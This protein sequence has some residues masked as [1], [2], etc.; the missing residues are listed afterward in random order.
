MK[1]MGLNEVREKFLSFFESK[2][3]LRLHSFPLVPK[4]DKSLLLINS[5]MAP[6]KPYFTGQEAPP[7]K[8]V[9]TCQKCIR[10]PDIDNAGKTARHGTFFEMLGNF[11]FGDYFKKEA[12]SWGWE[13]MTKMM[14]IPYE[15]LYVSIYE[16]DDEA[17][18]IWK[19]IIGLPDE[20]IVRLGKDDNF[21]EIGTG[22]CGPCSEI[23][24]DR[25]ERFGCGKSTCK[26]GC[27]CDRYMEVWNLVF[28]QFNR[29]DEGNYTPLDFPNIDT[30]MGLE[31]MAAVMQEAD[32]IFE[33]D[34][35]KSILDYVCAMSNK[36][37]GKDEK[38][39]ISIRVITDHIRS[40]VF[41][42]S[43]NIMPSNEGRGYVL[44]RLLRRAARHGKL[45]SIEDAFLALVAEKAIH[46][47]CESYPELAEKREYIL[48]VIKSEEEKF[49]ETISQGLNMLKEE[50]NLLLSENK[51]V[52]SGQEAFRMYDTFGF[53]VELTEEILEEYG[54]TLKKDEYE[55]KMK[56]QK[57]RAREAR[58]SKDVE[59]WND[60]LS[61]IIASLEATQFIGYEH[62]KVKAEVKAIIVGDHMAERL[63]KGQSGIIVLDKTPFYAESGGQVGDSGS[64][65]SEYGHAEIEDTQK[66][67]NKHLHYTKMIDGFIALG[68]EVTAMV[69]CTRR[70]DIQRNHSATH[71]LHKV[72]KR[73]LGEHVNQAG[74]LVEQNRLRFDFVHFEKITKNQL[75]KIE[76]EVNEAIFEGYDVTQ[77]NMSI[78][79]ARKT[80]A[81]ALFDEKYA[82]VVRVINMGGFSMELCG[83]CHI[84]NTS[85]IGLFKILS[86]GSVASSVRRIE[87]VTGR[88]AYENTRKTEEALQSVAHIAK[89]NIVSVVTKVEE[90]YD[91]IKELTKDVEELK[92][93]V[94]KDIFV[95]LLNNVTEINEIKYIASI[96]DNAS[97][98]EMRA[99]SDK[100]KDK[101]DMCV[102]AL[103]G[104]KDNKAMMILTA[105]KGVVKK[106]FKSGVVLKEAIAKT[107]GSGGGRADMAQG[108]VNNIKK[109][110]DAFS[111]IKNKISEL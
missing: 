71:L 27:D 55:L 103:A 49:N 24:V 81:T 4:T 57:N 13:F 58:F 66:N 80:G 37:Y 74:S 92:M 17:Y 19:D 108:G 56:E 29:D 93:I 26:V 20:K 78:E 61:E 98:E 90:A 100:F 8:R 52:F 36:E 64:V 82:N 67:A 104:K 72:L 21:W 12:I 85:K 63:D 40:V 77:S 91:T 83:G 95:Q 68:N 30:G 102:I 45:L 97:V 14:E 2:D 34:T 75:A 59:G 23:Y 10:T 28:T 110:D 51:T 32:S 107:G 1:Y 99:L 109:I 5:G 43:D 16:E 38:T 18:H 106:G 22:P 48:R 25:G 79:Q 70:T 101:F 62:L 73:E 35:V 94:N 6:L 42:I 39:D 41:M 44:R 47:S 65:V 84:D 15:L 9:A 96:V 76:H 11:S 60:S 53:P 33:V 111:V 50:I 7:H 69:D 89:T 105:S 54:M 88:Y 3:H 31:R 46:Q 87:A 86:E